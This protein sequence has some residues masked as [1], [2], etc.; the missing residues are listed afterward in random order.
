M[1][2]DKYFFINKRLGYFP[3][4]QTGHRP[5][6]STVN[7]RISQENSKIVN[8]SGLNS[9]QDVKSVLAERISRDVNEFNLIFSGKI[10]NP[11]TPLQVS[12]FSK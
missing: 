7:V 10:L 9:V 11:E 3:C 8:L 5:E 12:K 4:F 2:K 1:Q 6:M